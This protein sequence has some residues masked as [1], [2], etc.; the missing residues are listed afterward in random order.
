MEEM[1]LTVLPLLTKLS[2]SLYTRWLNWIE[3]APHRHM[4]T[5]YMLDSAVR[6]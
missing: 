1:I 6:Y 4:Y 2:S 3:R 5:A